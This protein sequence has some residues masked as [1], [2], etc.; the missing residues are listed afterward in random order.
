MLNYLRNRRCLKNKGKICFFRGRIQDTNFKRGNYAN[1]YRRLWRLSRARTEEAEQA[2]DRWF[3]KIPQLCLATHWVL[4]NTGSWLEKARC[5]SLSP[6]APE[7]AWPPSRIPVPATSIPLPPPADFFR[8]SI[9]KFNLMLRIIAL[10]IT[11]VPCRRRYKTSEESCSY[12][13]NGSEPMR[14]IVQW[15][16][17]TDIAFYPKHRLN[18]A[19]IMTFQLQPPN[20][21]VKVKVIRYVVWEWWGRQ[22][23]SMGALMEGSWFVVELVLKICMLMTHLSMTF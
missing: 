3:N 10:Q 19:E 11:A 1:F 22:E 14:S 15:G 21:N 16:S 17:P 20:W 13:K 23:E 9:T 4:Q 8:Q 6:G 5:A 18:N 12:L 7:T 2:Y